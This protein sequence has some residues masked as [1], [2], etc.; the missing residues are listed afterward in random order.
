MLDLQK[1]T[2]ILLI[3]AIATVVVIV[4]ITGLLMTAEKRPDKVA[5]LNVV[6]DELPK[7]NG[8]T[9]ASKKDADGECKEISDSSELPAIRYMSKQ[10]SKDFNITKDRFV[11]ESKRQG[12]SWNDENLPSSK[13]FER[14]GKKYKLSFTKYS[15]PVG[16]YGLDL[17]ACN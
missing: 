4:F 15:A 1:K 7:L 16:Y 10:S 3:S 17:T 8:Q 6:A 5:R 9:I 13:I 11:D 12:I 14:A 2:K